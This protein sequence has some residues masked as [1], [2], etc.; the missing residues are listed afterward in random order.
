MF[1]IISSIVLYKND[2]NK[3]QRII[4]SFLNT[5]LNVKLYLVDNSPTN[6]LK[7]LSQND[8]RVEYIFN[9][10]NIGFGA[11]HNIAINKSVDNTKY[12]LILNPDIYFD[13]GI[14]EKI[15]NFMQKNK[16]VGVT[17]PKILYPNDELQYLCKLCPTPFDLIIRRFFPIE[18]YVKKKNRRYELKFAD[19]NE[20]MEVPCLSGC[21]MFTRAKVLEE[22]GGFDDR[23]F[24]YL[25]DFDL[26]R[27]IN[28]KYRTIYYPEVAVYHEYG[29]GSYQNPKL[30][31]Y[32][33]KSAIKYFNKWG[34]FFDDERKEINQTILNNLKEDLNL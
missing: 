29:R 34:W 2:F 33:L 1:D 18:S 26:S 21:F 11:A 5:N 9:N 15:Y 23:Y 3:V 31:W 22:V 7:K 28:K 25:E 6:N 8:S 4:S 24:M 17:M 20:I 27:K 10:S 32:H 14:L 19:Y 16:N 13:Q 12:Y 30:L